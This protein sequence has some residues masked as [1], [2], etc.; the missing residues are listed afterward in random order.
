MTRLRGASRGAFFNQ[1]ERLFGQGTSIGSSEGE[2]LERFV[3][4]H[5]E[6]AF[7]ALVARHGPMVLGVC[8]Q[9]LRDPNDVDDAFQATFLVL[10][11][12]AGTLRRRDLLGNWLYGVAYRV[13]ARARSL[14]A[15]RNS[16]VASGHDSVES[17]TDLECGQEVGLDQTMLL[18]Q[19]PWLHQEVSHLPEKYRVPIVLCYFEGLTHDEAASR[20]GWPLG[21]VKGRLARARDLAPT[22]VDP[23]RRDALRDRARLSPRGPRGEGRRPGLLATDDTQGCLCFGLPG[24]CVT[25]QVLGCFPTGICFS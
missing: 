19:G 14:S 11:R 21:T 4:G 5:D 16:R 12:K 6:V 10:V 25:G 18:E 7:E 13:A 15:R 22:E 1:L 24:R 2:L 3:T 17:L 8:R 23:P 9:L 20:L